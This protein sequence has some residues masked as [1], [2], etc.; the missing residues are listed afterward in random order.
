MNRIQRK[1]SDT[2]RARI[3]LFFVP[4]TCAIEPIALASA[5]PPASA[6]AVPRS[7]AAARSWT[8][9]RTPHWR[10][11]V[12]VLATAIAPIAMKGDAGWVLHSAPS[13]AVAS[14][15][16]SAARCHAGLAAGLQT[17]VKVNER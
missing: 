3:R 5:V 9:F 11:V 17:L 16:G 15:A 1:R 4:A 7:A 14:S 6:I 2:I 10:G 8:N 13:A 12:V